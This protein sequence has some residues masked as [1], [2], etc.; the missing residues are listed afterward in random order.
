MFCSGRGSTAARGTIR[1]VR[2]LLCTDTCAVPQWAREHGCPWNSHVFSLAAVGGQLEVLQ[3]VRDFDANGEVWREDLVRH[4]AG[5][6][7]KQ[8]VLAWLDELSCK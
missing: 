8:E 6:A 1:H 4:Y 3:W 2:T 5:G 7:R